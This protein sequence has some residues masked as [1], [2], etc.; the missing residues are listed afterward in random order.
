ML[1]RLKQRK[2]DY[3]TTFNTEEGKRVLADLAHRHGV[4]ESVF[5][6]GDPHHTAFR[7]GKRSVV[8]DLLRYLNISIAELQR[9]EKLNERTSDE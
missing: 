6:P 3:D 7:E 5:V 9:L 1:R 8:T 2:Y 4:F